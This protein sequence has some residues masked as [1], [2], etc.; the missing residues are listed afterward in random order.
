MIRTPRTPPPEP[1]ESSER[2]LEEMDLQEIRRI[3]AQQ[4]QMIQQLQQSQRSTVIS[5]NQGSAGMVINEGTLGNYLHFSLRDALEA[6]PNFDGG[7]I[8]FIYFVEG[9]EEALSMITP[10]QEMNLVRAVRN[11]LKG[12]AHKTI[13]GKTFNSMQEFVEFLRT[14]YGSRKTVYEAQGRLAYLCQKKDEKVVAYAN[15]VREL[16]KRILDAQKR[17]TG[18]ISF[19]FRN[20][21]DKHLKSSF[22]QGLNKEI[23]I[24]KEGTFEEVESRA[25]EAER[26]L[27]T[28]NMIRR[29]VLAENITTEKRAPVR[30]MKGETVT[31]Q[32]CNKKGHTADKCWQI[33][34]RENN[35]IPNQNKFYPQ[36]KSFNNI[37]NNNNNNPRQSTFSGNTQNS[38]NENSGAIITCRYCKRLVIL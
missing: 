23:I 9:C 4:Q 30:Y 20:S 12:D 18:Q 6:V 2:S 1:A 31:C 32:Y 35:R 11:K 16:G 26:E 21:I 25:I 13:L 22:T 17:E 27:E 14:K 36:S 8:P 29:V 3:V 33:K 5:S 7:N 34:S 38:R 37:S 15:R 19:E 10:V 28:A 24:N